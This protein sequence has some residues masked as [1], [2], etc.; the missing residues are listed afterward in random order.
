[1]D[2]EPTRRRAGVL[3]GFRLA[4]LVGVV[5]VVCAADA[6]SGSSLSPPVNGRIAFVLRSDLFTIRPNGTGLMHLTS[7]RDVDDD[8][9]WSP[10]GRWLAFARMSRDSKVTS[11]YL[12]G[13]RGGQPRLLL[14]GARWPEWSPNGRRVAVVRDGRTCSRWCPRARDLWTVGSAGGSPRLALAGAWESDW[15]PS[16][17][18]LAAIRADGVW[19]VRVAS[20]AAR[21]VSSVRGGVS[22]DWSPDGSQLLLLASDGIITISVADGSVKTLVAPPRRPAPGDP[23]PPCSDSLS[24]PVWSPDGRWIAY[25]E[26][27]CVTDSGPPFDYYAIPIISAD[28]KWHSEI[29]NL[30]WGWTS[31]SGMSDFVWSPDSRML[32]YIDDRLMSQGEVLL[33]TADIAGINYEQLKGGLDQSPVALA[34]QRSPGR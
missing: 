8:P 26:I 9:A 1:M 17:H 12:V 31:D 30:V 24:D 10:G 3:R 5:L 23:R 27:R 25:Q 20:G 33:E 2:C 13:E 34:W 22:L 29:N 15:S 7:G 11:V 28:G 21:R 32:A 19:I 6:S 14:R 18:E 16:G 4:V